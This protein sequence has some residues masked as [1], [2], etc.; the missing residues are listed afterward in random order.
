M[1]QSPPI[2]GE[3]PEISLLMHRIEVVSHYDETV[4]ISGET[5]TGKELVARHIHT[6]SHRA[7]KPYIPVNCAALSAGTIDSE[8][9]GHTK[10]SFTGAVAERNGVFRSADEGTLF[11]DEVG[12]LPLPTQAKLLR[13]IEYGEVTPVGADR[14]VRVNVRLLAATNRDLH[15]MVDEGAFRA[16][17]LARL[18]QLDI[19]VP[20]LRNR[21]NDAR[22]LTN[23][24]IDNWC[25]THTQ[26]REVTPGALEMLDGYTWPGNVRELRNLITRVCTFSET[27]IIDV[28]DVKMH[29]A[30]PGSWNPVQP[31]TSSGTSVRLKDDPIDLQ[32]IL[33]ETERK[34]YEYAYRNARGNKAEAA[35][36][37]GIQPP[38]FR[39]ALKERFPD[40]IE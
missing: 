6:L 4:L 32:A 34:W 11:L 40:I 33:R 16:D 35:R 24:F 17:L 7:G 12:E 5:G 19:I 9:F 20:P 14:P 31:E 30:S 26:K 15:R 2:L 27:G 18:R 37:L 23:A 21:G 1:V 28:D 3:S 22:I 8:L 38:A 36:L 10:G 13:A 39:K 25:S 29:L